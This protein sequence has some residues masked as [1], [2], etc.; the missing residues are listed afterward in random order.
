MRSFVGWSLIC[1]L[2]APA[3]KIMKVQVLHLLRCF[4]H[5]PSSSGFSL[6]LRLFKAPTNEMKVKMKEMEM[7]WQSTP[8]AGD[9]TGNAKEERKR[10]NTN[11]NTP[12]PELA[13][14]ERAREKKKQTDDGPNTDQ[15]RGRRSE[16][17]DTTYTRREPSPPRHAK[18][19]NLTYRG[20]THE[21]GDQWGT[22]FRNRMQKSW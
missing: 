14:P 1:P 20:S 7:R 18:D 11:T 6:R 15:G 13:N 8:P 16:A 3:T 5:T 17:P 21:I 10:G 22:S 12:S 19:P 9:E 4:T 2:H